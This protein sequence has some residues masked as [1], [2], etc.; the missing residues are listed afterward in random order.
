[1]CYKAHWLHSKDFCLM[2][3][4]K[5]CE[6]VDFDER[7][8]ASRLY[9]IKCYDW[10]NDAPSLL[11]NSLKIIMNIFPHSLPRSPPLSVA[12]L[13][14]ILNS[15]IFGIPFINR[16]MCAR[17][18]GQEQGW[19][20]KRNALFY[21]KH[22]YAFIFFI[23]SLLALCEFVFIMREITQK[24]KE[25]REIAKDVQEDVKS[26]DSI[27]KFSDTHKKRKQTPYLIQW[28]TTEWELILRELKLNCIVKYNI[29]NCKTWSEEF[30]MFH[31]SKRDMNPCRSHPM[32]AIMRQQ[33]KTCTANGK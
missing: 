14:Y 29:L 15:V 27:N 12:L 23:F 6:I 10:C 26:W 8:S 2:R 16:K 17:W 9:S 33:K 3:K 22:V 11:T 19:V 31:E 20:N 21:Y 25:D 32:G 28:T 13:W 30:A 4:S 18:Q 5:K 7:R 24:I 1:M